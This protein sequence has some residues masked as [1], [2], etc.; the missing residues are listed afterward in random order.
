M[1]ISTEKFHKKIGIQEKTVQ[2]ST[3]KQLDKFVSRL[4]GKD[5]RFFETHKEAWSLLK[6]FDRAFWLR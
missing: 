1:I 6:S 2:F 5:P 4:L 3:H